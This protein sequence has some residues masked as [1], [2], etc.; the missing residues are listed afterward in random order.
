[1]SN[2]NKFLNKYSFSSIE[3]NV[4]GIIKQRKAHLNPALKRVAEYV[5]N[6][7]EEC[8]SLTIKELSEFCDV[9][10]ST[11]TRFV[12]EIGFS[13]YQQLK[14]KLAETVQSQKDN[15]ISDDDNKYIYEN[16][17]N[18]DTVDDILNKLIFKN[19]TILNQTKLIADKSQYEEAAKAIEKANILSFS[20]TGSSA[21]AAEEAIMRFTRAGIKC[22]FN[23][24]SAIQQMTSSILSNNDVQIGISDSGSTSSVI[25]SLKQA[26]SNGITTIAITSS[27]KS[28]VAEFA[29]IVLLTSSNN[30]SDYAAC[31]NW[32]NTSSKISQILVIDTLY[33]LYASRNYNKIKE[34][35]NRT[36]KS[37]SYTR[38]NG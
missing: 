38:K 5:L 8:K 21:I 1:M 34:N 22:I 25:N 26:K 12:K 2:E 14:I 23:R 9:S 32:E 13:N 10:E 7:P 31:D 27:N 35:L 4:L 30:S 33:A 37:I 11:V 3:N 19:I 29:D 6:D 20:C 36:Y 16:I 17:T 15:A 18:T 24:D 28:K